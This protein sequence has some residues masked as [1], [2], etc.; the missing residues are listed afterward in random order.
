M[1]DKTLYS[2]RNISF[3]YGVGQPAALSVP[4]MDIGEG[5][6]VMLVGPNGSGKTTFLKMLNDLL[7]TGAD[8][9]AF[10]GELAFR[11]DL[12]LKD[13][14]RYHPRSVR[15]ATVYM[16]QHPYILSGS[17]AHN[18]NFACRAKGL[19][20]QETAKAS[21]E[22]LELVGLG[23]Y[24]VRKQ[25]GLSGGEAQ[26]LALAR[27]IASGAEI[28]LLDEPTASA[29][30]ASRDR[31]VEALESLVEKGTTILFSTHET[32]I[33][34]RLGRRVLEFERGTIIRDTWR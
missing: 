3:S 29:D 28:L 13:G 27:V 6:C 21:A 23:G 4:R 18:L 26:R 5:E 1:S 30:A 32:E 24:A 10:S 14:A 9:G 31:I 11:G 33:M 16:H 2:A 19:S 12:V 8:A 34:A 17:V 22:A 25:K 20:S 15:T 7:P